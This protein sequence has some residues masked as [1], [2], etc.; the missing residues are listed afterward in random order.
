MF[1]KS[2]THLVCKLV[3]VVLAVTA[4][5]VDVHGQ[6]TRRTAIVAAV[7]KT[8]P[9]IVTIKTPNP[10]GGKDMIGAGVIIDPRGYVVTNRHVTAGKK[11]VKV[12]L[13]DGTE[14]SGSVLVADP[15]FDLAVIRIKTDKEL[16]ALTLNP[17][18]D[19]M[20]G[21]TVFAVGNPLGYEGT[22]SRGIISALN[23]KV[24]MP[25]D[26]V[27]TGLIQ[28]DAPINPGSS[29]G[30]LVNLDAEVIGINVAMRD[31]AQNIAFAINAQTI[32]GVLSR[33]VSAKNIAGITHGMTCTNKERDS[34]Q[35]GVVVA[36]VAKQSPAA[37]A[38]IQRGDVVV[39]M[40][41]QAVANRLDVER[42]FWD[43]K[44]GERVSVTV[45]REEQERKMHI[46]VGD[47][48]DGR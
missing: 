26:V 15:H 42:A 46:L 13:H 12:R 18:D 19:L 17:A 14:L 43:R 5:R 7:E 40:A 32:D 38:G 20:V 35:P 4:I 47:V 41:G 31:N 6:G 27:M 34:A 16:A 36:S 21:E 2:P 3:L 39:R 45:V 33:L 48:D 30:P 23:R 9:S 29:G 28:H 44:P 37:E 1:S 22:V 11:Q 10:Q 24:V 25:N 8:R